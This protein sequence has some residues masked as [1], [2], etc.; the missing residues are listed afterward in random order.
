MHSF[1][2]K[3]PAK[4]P[5]KSPK[6]AEPVKKKTTEP[7]AAKEVVPVSNATETPAAEASSEATVAQPEAGAKGS[8]PAHEWVTWKP[9]TPVPYQVF[10][11]ALEKVAETTK[12]LEVFPS[13]TPRHACGLC[14]CEDADL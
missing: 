6:P 7:P 5:A 4:S 12:R 1:F 2:A 8:D 10:A 11:A 3:K 14:D 13:L 9:G